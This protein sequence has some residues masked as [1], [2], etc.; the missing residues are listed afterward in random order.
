MQIES[1]SIEDLAAHRDRA[2]TTLSD[3][4]AARQKELFGGVGKGW[5][6]RH[7]IALHSAS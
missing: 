2:I 4:V 6:A 7:L 1:L 5:G 3:K